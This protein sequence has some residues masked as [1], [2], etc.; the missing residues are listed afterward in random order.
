MNQPERKLIHRL[1]EFFNLSEQDQHRVALKAFGIEEQ[2]DRLHKQYGAI[3]TALQSTTAQDENPSTF[4]RDAIEGA[5]KWLDQELMVLCKNAD[6][7]SCRILANIQITATSWTYMSR[8]W[9][10][11]NIS[12]KLI[13]AYELM[14]A[15]CDEEGGVAY[16]DLDILSSHGMELNKDTVFPFLKDMADDEIPVALSL[17]VARK[18]Y[19]LPFVES[20]RSFNTT[21]LEGDALK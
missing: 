1:S 21:D 6:P 15:C 4:I 18:I 14:S 11:G 9:V 7:E 10:M 20:K 8:F 16:V 13:A 17:D 2:Y 19:E 5:K 3:V 12:Q